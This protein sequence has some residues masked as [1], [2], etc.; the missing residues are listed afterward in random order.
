MCL[1][2][3][4]S[5]HVFGLAL[6][7]KISRYLFVFKLLFDSS[8]TQKMNVIQNWIGKIK[9]AKEYLFSPRFFYIE[10]ASKKNENF[11][12]RDGSVFEIPL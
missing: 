2:Y 11:L 3:F 8:I 1:F 12:S 10:K 9:L 7:K 4:T 6:E 5:M